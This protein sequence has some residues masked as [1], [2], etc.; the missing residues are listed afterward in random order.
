M[1][2]LRLSIAAEPVTSLWFMEGPIT[3]TRMALKNITAAKRAK[4]PA[5][6]MFFFLAWAI[7]ASPVEG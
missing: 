3:P 4:L 1:A 2:G 5:M 7:S 6:K